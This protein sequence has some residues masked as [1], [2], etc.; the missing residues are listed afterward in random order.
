[1]TDLNLVQARAF[2]DTVRLGSF[3]AAAERAG[4]TQ[5][6]ISL[7]V[8][9]LEAALGVRL[10]DRAGKRIRA[11]PAGAVL[12]ERFPRV[13][14]ELAG[15]IEAL[16]PFRNG[17]SDRIRIGTGATACIYLLPPILET[18]KKEMPGLEIV[19]Q[20]GNT[21]EIVKQVEMNALDVGLVTLPI[22][23]K[24]LAVTEIRRDPLLA[25]A[26]PGAHMP[27]RASASFLAAQPLILYEDGG[28]TRRIVDRW[29][30]RAGVAATP[31]MA[32][33][34][35]EAI[36]KL[37]AA[38]LGWSVLP[39]TA[40]QAETAAG[41]LTARPLSPPLDRRLGIVL[42]HNKRLSRGLREL[43]AALPPGR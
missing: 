36:K 31:I 43:V 41:T 15:A 26:A 11:T 1:M 38:G 33:G 17:A 35:V 4:L 22:G 30:A 42:R 18:L 40:M 23:G 21:P 24:A 9:Q 39:A 2:C 29:F 12:L 27:A 25:V 5:P 19:V 13:E 7:Q 32:L 20:T 6:A 16:Q 10:V 3:S 34:S 14:A 8:R 37:V 28:N